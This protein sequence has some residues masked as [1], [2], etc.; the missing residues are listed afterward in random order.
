MYFEL[1]HLFTLK[2]CSKTGNAIEN[3]QNKQLDSAV[4]SAWICIFCRSIDI[5]HMAKEW[6]SKHFIVNNLAEMYILSMC[7]YTYNNVN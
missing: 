2:N 4:H 7:G 6:A 3:E 1:Y 5:P